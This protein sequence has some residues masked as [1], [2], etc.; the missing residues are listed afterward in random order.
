[1]LFPHQNDAS[2]VRNMVNSLRL[3]P[4]VTVKVIFHLK[5]RGCVRRLVAP[6]LH[7]CEAV[8]ATEDFEW[9]Y[10]GLRCIWLC[11]VFAYHLLI[12]SSFWENS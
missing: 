2:I 4:L 1:M 8:K 10:I 9:L 5:P 6:R 11:V 3:A 7:M 12:L